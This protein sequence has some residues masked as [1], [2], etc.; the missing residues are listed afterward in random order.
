MVLLL[1]GWLLTQAVA[2]PSR[3]ATASEIQ[4]RGRLIVA[5]KDNSPP[6]GF[7]QDGELAGLEIDLA[8]QLA[9]DL[10][11]DE[12][13]VT[14][15]PVHND[16]RLSVL[17]AGEVD[18]V[19]A[20][21]TATPARARLVDFSS[22]YYFDGT[23]FVTKDPAIDR[24]PNLLRQPI[25]VLNGSSTI[26]TVRSLLPSALLV[27]ANSYQDAL[28]LLETNR[29]IAFAAD[30]SIL[31]GWVQELPQYR[32]IEQLISAEALSVA[33][34]KGNRYSSLRSRV[35]ASIDRLRE[36]G[37]LADRLRIWGLPE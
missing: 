27:G 29:A 21:M 17:L 7:L 33:M 16:R 14:F 24:L 8:R 32:R 23:A 28:T 26:A 3:A 35:N 22:P 15:V 10:L 5:V 13:E 18:L 31:T 12:A 6:L 37:W 9:I 19:I 11:G 1:V 36:T 2:L 4:E 20:R 25:A 30:A 34:P